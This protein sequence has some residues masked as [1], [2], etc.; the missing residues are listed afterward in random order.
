M[1]I[2]DA[3]QRML[4]VGATLDGNTQNGL[5]LLDGYVQVPSIIRYDVGIVF[6]VAVRIAAHRR[7]RRTTGAADSAIA[8]TAHAIL[9]GGRQ[10][11]HGLRA[12]R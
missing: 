4:R 1:D 9:F 10:S 2:N 12:Q 8:A 6:L 5:C 7:A 11:L 3:R